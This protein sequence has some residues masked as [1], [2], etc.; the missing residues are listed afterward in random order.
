MPQP[1]N[2]NNVP[3]NYF[4]H[5]VDAAREAQN[6]QAPGGAGVQPADNVVAGEAPARQAGP[7]AT[8]VQQLDVLLVKAAKASTQ[9]LDGKTVKNSLLKLVT[10]GA[11]D[12]D[13]LKLLGKTADTAA[14][15]LKALNKITGAQL[16][17]AIK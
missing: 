9:S 1:I 16:A 17:A 12:K 4:L 13:S 14:M 10:D 2:I 6:A 15:T 8:M 3:M 7:A 11:L 5:G